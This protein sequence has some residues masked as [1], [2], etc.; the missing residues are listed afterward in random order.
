MRA[1]VCACFPYANHV[2]RVHMR[3]HVYLETFNATA[4]VRVSSCMHEYARWV[5]MRGSNE[6]CKWQRVNLRQLTDI[7]LIFSYTRASLT[8][9]RLL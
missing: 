2:H 3:V 8:C 9:T 6:R 7:C 5:S 1:R 4:D